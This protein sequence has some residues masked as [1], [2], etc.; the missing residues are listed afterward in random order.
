MM[1]NRLKDK[2]VLVTGAS[3]GL[4]AE[5]AW[6]LAE[7]GAVP[8][9]AARSADRLEKLSYRLENELGATSYTYPVDLTDQE[10][11]SSVMREIMDTHPVID[12]LIN[13]AGIGSFKWIED[14]DME[15][16]AYMLE[17]NVHSL[18]RVTKQLLPHLQKQGSGH[19]VNVA[20]QA[21]KIATPKSA[22]YAASKHAVLGFTNALRL[23]VQKKGIYVTAVNPG[24]VSTRFFDSADPEGNYVESVQRYMLEPGE[25]AEKVIKHLFTKKREINM[26]WWM[27]TGSRLYSQFPD[28]MEKLL[29][30]QFNRK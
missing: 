4:G 7:H 12:A 30:S 27:E 6:K 22:V 2:K 11:V 10:A 17:L 19:I 24:P 8:L 15:E 5:L 9:L 26:P 13:N 16:A 3:S 28:I 25:V 23:E 21:G 20:S 14:M 1:R 18:I 29:K